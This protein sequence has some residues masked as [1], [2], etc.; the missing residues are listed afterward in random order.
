LS[1]KL[2]S[3]FVRQGSETK[4]VWHD[5]GHELRQTEIEEAAAFLRP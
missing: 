2:N 5:G 4:L 3:Y 1:E